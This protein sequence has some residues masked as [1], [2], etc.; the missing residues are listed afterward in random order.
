VEFRRLGDSGLVVSA[1]GLGTNNFG[2]RLQDEAARAVLNEAL[3]EGVTLIDTA[4]IYGRGSDEGLGASESQLG[5]LLAG[6]RQNLVLATKFGFAMGESVYEKG[7]SRG[8]I[9]RAVEGSLRRLRT[10]YIDLYQLHTPDPETPIEETLRALD[11]LVRA[12]KVRYTGTSNL[13]AWQIVD[14]DWAARANRLSRPISAQMHY[15]LLVRGI[16]AEVIPACR[17]LG[18]G[19]IPYFPL[20]SGF[21]TGK[22]RA[23]VEG[24]GRLVESARAREVLTEANFARLENLERFA[25]ERGHH[26]LDLAFGWLL[27]QTIVGSVIAS[28]STPAQ[29]K[30]NVEAAAWRLSG[31]EMDEVGGL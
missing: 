6:R 15:N 13:A 3:E 27:S 29:V 1:V 7:A 9:E 22:Y 30:A 8:W 21:L 16:Q 11:D 31:D 4:D 20:E 19:I 23:G 17:K 25:T 2:G 18:L 12:G 10:D 14:A 5:R 26:V 28:A 24:R